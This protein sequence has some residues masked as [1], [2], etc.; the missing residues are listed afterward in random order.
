MDLTATQGQV[1]DI[2]QKVGSVLSIVG[3]TF[4]ITT[5]LFSSKFRK[6]INRLV[7]YATWGNI[8]ANV[9]TLIGRSSIAIGLDSPLCQFQAFLIQWS[10]C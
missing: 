10:V 6:P 5:F 2:T 7:F 3:E 8:F 9:A 1:I 4:V